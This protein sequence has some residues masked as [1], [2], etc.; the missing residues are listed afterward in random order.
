M[1]KNI[2]ALA[3]LLFIHSL[4]PADAFLPPSVS[5]PTTHPSSSLRPYLSTG[6]G[7]STALAAKKK[8]KPKD[9]TITVNRIAYRNYE[10]IDTLE[11]GIALLGTEVKA[12]RDGKMNLRDGYIRPSKNGRSCVLHNVHI[13][14]HSMAG[15]FFQHEEKRPRVLLVHKE[16]ARK[17]LQQT[18]QSGMTLIPIKAYFSDFNMVKIQIALCRGKNVRDKRVTIKERDAKREESRII[19]SFRV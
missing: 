7:S 9:T 5:P 8:K 16:Q 3:L 14:K 11:A 4:C 10:I 1:R 18:E 17:F 13:G 2:S 19:K 15:A 12:I 6:M